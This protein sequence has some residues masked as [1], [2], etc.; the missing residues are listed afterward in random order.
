[1]IL[2]WN[3]TFYF[4][5]LNH[6]KTSKNSIWN[7]SNPFSKARIME[8]MHEIADQV[9]FLGESGVGG[10]IFIYFYVTCMTPENQC[11]S[12]IWWGS[13]N[14]PWH[15]FSINIRKKF[16]PSCSCRFV[17]LN[18]SFCCCTIGVGNRVD[19]LRIWSILV[20]KSPRWTG[21]NG[22]NKIQQAPYWTPGLIMIVLAY[23]VRC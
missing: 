15:N 7:Y 1:M 11:R 10:I 23:P 18:C 6:P 9:G 13:C 21:V 5:V 12:C 16:S 22:V 14:T 3:V 17:A 20:S 4:G 2:I 19:S 8:V